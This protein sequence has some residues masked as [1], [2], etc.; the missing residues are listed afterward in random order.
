MGGKFFVIKNITYA[1]SQLCI[2]KQ[3]KNEKYVFK[4]Y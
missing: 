2:E 4:K 1:T 3:K